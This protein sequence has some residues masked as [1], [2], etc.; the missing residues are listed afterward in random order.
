[1]RLGM[2]SIWP[3]HPFASGIEVSNFWLG[4]STPNQRDPLARYTWILLRRYFAL[5]VIYGTS[6]ISQER[7]SLGTN[8][9]GIRCHWHRKWRR[10]VEG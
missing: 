5:V 1:M 8:L 6:T 2:S 9:P 10:G 4:H 3:S 7:L